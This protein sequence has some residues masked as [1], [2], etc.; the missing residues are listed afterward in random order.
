MYGLERMSNRTVTKTFGKWQIFQYKLEQL[1]YKYL[2]FF[3]EGLSRWMGVRSLP[4]FYKKSN[5]ET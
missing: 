5:Y 1:L 3:K 4:L 2:K